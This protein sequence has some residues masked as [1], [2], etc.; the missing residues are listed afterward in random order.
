MLKFLEMPGVRG[1]GA[2]RQG[3]QR[4]GLGGASS[5]SPA[6]IVNQIHLEFKAYRLQEQ[7]CPDITILV[8]GSVMV[9]IMRSDMESFMGSIMI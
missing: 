8:I 4:E 1:G 3:R 9:S 2:G 6:N 7:K 5:R